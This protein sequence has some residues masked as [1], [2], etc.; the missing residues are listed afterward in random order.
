MTNGYRRGGTYTRNGQQFTRRGTSIKAPRG[1]GVAA[2][3]GVGAAAL[4]GSGSV[5]TIG[6]AVVGVGVVI[7]WRYRR[8][9]RPITRRVERWASKR[10]GKSKPKPRYDVFDPFTG[11]T[12]KQVQGERQ[13]KRVTRGNG[14]DY[15]RTQESKSQDYDAMDEPWNN[16]CAAGCGGGS[17]SANCN[18]PT[19]RKYASHRYSPYAHRTEL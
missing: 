14:L 15:D 5:L 12:T 1:L 4:F 17:F 8:Q 2:G 16:G 18:I 6:V 9:L 19:H 10:M 13:A 7:G 3:I 11:R